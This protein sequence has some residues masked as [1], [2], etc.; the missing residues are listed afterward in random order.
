[1]LKELL[2]NVTND[3][4]TEALC[5]SYEKNFKENTSYTVSQRQQNLI[6]LKY[7]QVKTALVY[8]N[9][10]TMLEHFQQIT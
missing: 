7:M 9:S 6:V 2:F 5:F 10:K 1:M 3:L 8:N 4:Y